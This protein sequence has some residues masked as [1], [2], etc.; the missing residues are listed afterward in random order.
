MHEL[1]DRNDEP[2]CFVVRKRDGQFLRGA[3]FWKWTRNW[4]SAAILSRGFVREFCIGKRFG[5]NS[6]D[7]LEFY[8]V[9][10]LPNVTNTGE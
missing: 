3:R 2:L 4:R 8:T 6:I 1:L 9:Q 7:E 5:I 10:M